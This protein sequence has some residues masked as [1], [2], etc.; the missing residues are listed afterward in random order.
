MTVRHGEFKP[1]GLV[2]AVLGFVITRF[3]VAESMNVDAALPFLI[4]AL[5]P[6]V[7]GFGL[8]VFGVALTIG[9]FPRTYVRTVTLWTLAGTSAMTIVLVLT[10]SEM[11]LTEGMTTTPFESTVLVAN[12]LLGGAVGGAL[13][14]DRTAANRRSR[15]EIARQADRAVL[16]NRILRHEV[17]NAAAIVQ[18]YAD[19]LSRSSDDDSVA[20]V[21]EAGERIETTVE[22]V[23]TI[24][25]D[26]A[27]ELGPIDVSAVATQEADRYDGRVTATV[28]ANTHALVDHRIRIVVRELLANAVE[29]GAGDVDGGDAGDADG[30]GGSNADAGDGGDVDAGDDG[31]ADDAVTIA[32]TAEE[33][34]VTV[35]VADDGPGM[36]DRH[37]EL[38]ETGSLPEYDDP[39]S[40]FGLQ[41]VRLLVERYDGAVTVDTDGGTTVTVSL[42]RIDPDG[43]PLSALGVERSALLRAA[44]VALVAGVVM[45]V[46]MQVTAGLLPVI[47]ALYGVQSELVGWISHLFHSIV[48][49]LLFVAGTTRPTFRAFGGVLGLTL[50][51][52]L[53][54]AVLWLIAA[55]FIMP[56]WLIA[57]GEPAIL[58]NLTSPGLV[59][60]LLWGAVLG[61][62]YAV[63]TR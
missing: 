7:A 44:G 59:S 52:S 14:G 54:G 62:L 23:G 29:H 36:A 12:V 56:L 47:G 2:V 31:D 20:A 27:T 46:F 55:G 1:E 9:T 13:T 50:L 15:D 21:K 61:G 4:A 18:G 19:L 26:S 3:A 58:P 28:E 16:I 51:G 24:A 40:G 38:L 6:L 5:L 41:T 32:V 11:F 35:R 63:L 49:G 10:A 8:S 33:R 25:D 30:G 17:L 42:P 43:E 39:T 57:V 53:W 22:E 34:T 60:H 45:G 48:F 37:R